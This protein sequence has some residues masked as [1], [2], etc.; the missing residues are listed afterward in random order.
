MP[1]RKNA[2]YAAV[3]DDEVL[4]GALYHRRNLG[5]QILIHEELHQVWYA[6]SVRRLLSQLIEADA[7][8]HASV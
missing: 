2:W 8:A 3:W 7:S 6:T 4:P 1:F 5:E